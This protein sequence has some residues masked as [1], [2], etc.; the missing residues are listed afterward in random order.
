MV[1]LTVSHFPGTTLD[2]L[3]FPLNSGQTL[4]DTPG[5]TNTNHYLPLLR[6][7]ELPYILPRRCLR[8]VTYRLMAGKTIFL[9]T[10]V[11]H[12]SALESADYAL[13]Y[14]WLSARRCDCDRQLAFLL[15]D[16]LCFERLDPL[17]ARHTHCAS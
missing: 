1:D 16:V 6:E 9:G 11:L 17:S 4:Y 8:P 14:R 5:V 10:L 2:I 15:R 12:F 13:L 3:S 7:T